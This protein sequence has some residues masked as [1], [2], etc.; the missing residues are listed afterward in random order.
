[1]VSALSIPR[2]FQLTRRHRFV[3]MALAIIAAGTFLILMTRGYLGGNAPERFRTCSDSPLFEDLSLNEV[4]SRY[5]YTMQELVEER[6]RLYEGTTLVQCDE[7]KMEKIIPS[8][9]L[10]REVAR[11][12]PDVPDWPTFSYHHFE[13]LL[14]EFWRTYDCELFSLLQDEY[15]YA[16]AIGIEDTDSSEFGEFLRDRDRVLTRERMRARSAF[17]RLM[18]VL[19]ASEKNLPLHTSLRCLQRGAADVRNAMSLVSDS[20]QCLPARLGQPETS[21]RQ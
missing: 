20:A 8:G 7:E 14:H 4:R 17:D 13:L 18:M 1:M 9:D 12:L 16:K 21:L 6:M 3:A 11:T 2:H 10:A 19:R 5:H 15:A